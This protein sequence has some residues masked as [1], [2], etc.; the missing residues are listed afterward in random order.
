MLTDRYFFICIPRKKHL[1]IICDMQVFLPRELS[2][3]RLGFASYELVETGVDGSCSRARDHYGAL[4]G[5][6]VARKRAVEGVVRVGADVDLAAVDYRHDQGVIKIPR[7]VGKLDDVARTHAV[8]GDR[9][10]EG[11]RAAVYGGEIGRA[12]DEIIEIFHTRPGGRALFGRDEIPAVLGRV[13]LHA[14]AREDRLRHKI[15][16]V[17]AD[18]RVIL[19]DRIA[20]ERPTPRIFDRTAAVVGDVGEIRI[21][22]VIH[23]RYLPHA[24]W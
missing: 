21:W 18:A 9:I 12:G 7:L 4:G 22:I 19:E 24:R 6:V 3:H 2:P 8:E 5:V 13:I 14:G 1:H 15:R 11:S 16:A 20:L 10:S 23:F 17:T